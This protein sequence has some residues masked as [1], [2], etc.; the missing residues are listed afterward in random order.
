LLVEKGGDESLIATRVP[1]ARFF[2]KMATSL[3]C[4][5]CTNVPLYVATCAGPG[6]PVAFQFIAKKIDPTLLRLIIHLGQKNPGFDKFT[7]KQRPGFTS[8][9]HCQQVSMNY[10]SSVNQG[11]QAFS[12]LSLNLRPGLPATRVNW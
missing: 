2:S 9:I 6:S 8:R 12:K 3:L 5:F 4:T 11:D 10:P 1:A 7:R